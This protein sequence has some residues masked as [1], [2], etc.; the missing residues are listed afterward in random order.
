MREGLSHL[1]KREKKKKEEEVVLG[2]PSE[3][4]SI[5]GEDDENPKSLMGLLIIKSHLHDWLALWWILDSDILF[6]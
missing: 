3:R 6:T 4:A 5:A 1:R 2:G